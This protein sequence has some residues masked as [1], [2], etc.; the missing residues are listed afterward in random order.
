MPRRM[1]RTMIISCEAGGAQILSSWIGEICPEGN[2]TYCLQ[3]P[4]EAIFRTRLGDIPRVELDA[5]QSLDRRFDRIMT[6]TSW[7]PDLERRAIAMTREKGIHSISVLD[8]WTNYRERFLPHHL[9]GAIP[10]DWFRYLPDEVWICDEYAHTLARTLGFP[11]ERLTQIENPYLAL[12]G[13]SLK[14]QTSKTLVPHAGLRLL[15]I[16]EPM[17]DDLEKTYGD[18][19]YWGYTEYDL[20]KSLVRDINFFLKKEIDLSVRMRLHPNE[21]AGKYDT[22]IE[23]NPSILISMNADLLDDL[24]WADA[25]VGGES[26]AL[27]IAVLAGK[28]VFSVIP[29][30]KRKQCA[31]PHREIRHVRSCREALEYLMDIDSGDEIILNSRKRI[32]R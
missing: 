4:A 26:M 8:H 31:L 2:Y 24:V 17:A 25:V 23:E 22:L 9:W 27:V 19:N 10:D 11:A 18:A 16:S 29:E 32:E 13:R 5:I 7:M 20:V 28:Q 3:G 14:D 12:V 1:S 6:G 30:S 21:V 15:Y